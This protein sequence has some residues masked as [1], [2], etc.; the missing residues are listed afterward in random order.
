MKIDKI[1]LAKVKIKKSINQAKDLQH[2]NRGEVG[3][4]LFGYVYLDFGSWLRC[5]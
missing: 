1:D 5:L 2:I 3:H 4:G